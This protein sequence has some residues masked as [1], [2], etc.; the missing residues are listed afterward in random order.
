MPKSLTFS[1]NRWNIRPA[2][3]FASPGGLLLSVILGPSRSPSLVSLCG[4]KP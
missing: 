1:I 4:P 2:S 3:I